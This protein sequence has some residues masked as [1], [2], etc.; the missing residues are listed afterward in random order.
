LGGARGV[1][2]LQAELA[3]CHA[4]APS[5]AETDWPMIVAL[6]DAL[7][8]VAPTPVVELN[9]AVA[10]SMASGPGAALAIVDRLRDAA[11]LKN[12]HW[13]PGVRADL[14]ARLGRV[15]EARDEFMRAAGLA[16]NAREREFLLERS[17]EMG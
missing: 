12:Y 16:R 2:A 17:R 3:A 1:Y 8:E 4:R 5:A 14:L 9:R 10:M 11:A 7:M 6:Y 13:L 15:D